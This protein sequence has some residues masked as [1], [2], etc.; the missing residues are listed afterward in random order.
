MHTRWPSRLRFGRVRPRDQRGPNPGAGGSRARAPI[1]RRAISAP[2][3]APGASKTTYVPY[4]TTRTHPHR[5][6]RT[7][8]SRCPRYHPGSLSCTPWATGLDHKPCGDGPTREPS[9]RAG[10]G[11]GCLG[12]SPRGG[13]P[14]L[15]ARVVPGSAAVSTPAKTGCGARRTR[16]VTCE[17]TYVPCS[18]SR[19]HPHRSDHTSPSREP[20]GT[21][22]PSG[23][24]HRTARM[25]SLNA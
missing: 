25:V 14:R 13:G 12:G 11:L 6:D 10:C 17:T 21:E 20:S 23:L 24:I 2:T 8:P 18:T 3:S 16:R 7:S 22:V 1:S 9:K 19:T 4:S 5:S 15:D